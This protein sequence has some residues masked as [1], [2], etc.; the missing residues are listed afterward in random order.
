MYNR[1]RKCGMFSTD[2]N[3]RENYVE[4][5]VC[6]YKEPFK[7]LPLFCLTGAC[8]AGK[9]TVGLEL[10]GSCEEFITLEG[11]IVWI[12]E[13]DNTPENN[14]RGYRERILRLVK[15]IAQSGKPVLLTGCTTPGQFE[16]CNERKF[17]GNIYYIAVVCDNEQLSKRLLN[18]DHCSEEFIEGQKQFN[19][20]FRDNSSKYEPN[21]FLVENSDGDIKETAQKVKK[22]VNKLLLKENYKS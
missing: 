14:Y 3:V 2:K 1:C 18:R 11:D 12:N 17:I 22:I 5:P 20:W 10:I 4:C 21:I 16:V 9:S 19:Q 6:G 8:G 15:N 13:I 7:K